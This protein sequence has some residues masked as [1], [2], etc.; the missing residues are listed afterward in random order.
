M[1][2]RAS[3]IAAALSVAFKQSLAAVVVSVCL[4]ISTAAGASVYDFTFT[5]TITSATTPIIAVGDTFTITLPL[6]NGGSTLV[7]QTWRGADAISGFTIDAGAYHASYSTLFPG[8]LFKT[9]A[10]GA[11]TVTR[12]R[13]TDPTSINQ[14]NFGSF[15]GDV[16]FASPFFFDFFGRQDNYAARPSKVADWTV[17][18]AATPLP[19]ALPLFAT[20]LGALGLFGWRRKRKAG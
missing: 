11:L 7:S 3:Y 12:F 9:N 13:G 16:V 10:S 2:I 18:A 17:T 14:D 5:S 15:V 4:A 20:G 19:A 6:D 1:R 8:L